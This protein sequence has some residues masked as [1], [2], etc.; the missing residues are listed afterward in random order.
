V[1]LFFAVRFS[2]VCRAAYLYRALCLFFAVC[3][4]FAVRFPVVAR[5]RRLCRATTH[6]KEKVAGNASFSRSG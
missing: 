2:V 1:K 5:Q 6:G 4:C 3:L